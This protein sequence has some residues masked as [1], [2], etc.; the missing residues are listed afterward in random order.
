MVPLF[1][2]LLS[3]F[4]L[5]HSAVVPIDSSSVNVKHSGQDYSYS[6]NENRGIAIDPL[7][8]YEIPVIK[9]APGNN[10]LVKQEHIPVK[11]HEI[12]PLQPQVA[13][14]GYSTPVA[15][16]PAYSYLPAHQYAIPY[17]Y[18]INYPYNLIATI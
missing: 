2:L 9:T 11:D 12:K 4:A 3:L 14:M 18:G 15:V 16:L 13:G 8:H 17:P 6:I 1:A 10:N 5:V 7:P